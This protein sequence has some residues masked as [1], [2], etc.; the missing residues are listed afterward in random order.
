MDVVAGG[1]A[2]FVVVCFFLMTL[3]VVTEVIEIF[4]EDVVGEEDGEAVGFV[5]LCCCLL[6][7]FGC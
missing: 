1:V 2:A 6:R 5:E 3:T 7:C 4:G